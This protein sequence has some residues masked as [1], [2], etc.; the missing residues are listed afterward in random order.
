M[1]SN[2]PSLCVLLALTACQVPATLPKEM[3][4]VATDA[5]A[6]RSATVATSPTSEDPQVIAADSTELVLVQ[7]ALS[8]LAVLR[9]TALRNI[10]NANTPGY[11]RRVIATPTTGLRGAGDSPL[12]VAAHEESFAVFTNGPLQV[13]GRSLDVAIEGDGFF[14]VTLPSGETAFT[15]NSVWHVNADGKLVT[16]QGHVL[17]PEITV[18]SDLL[19]LSVDPCGGVGG[20]TAGSPATTTMFGDLT[21]HRFVNPEGLRADGT[22]WMPTDASGSPITGAPGQAGLGVLQQ[23]CIERSNVELASELLTLQSIDQQHRSIVQ[24]LR[25]LGMLAH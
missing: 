25:E 18:P 5:T 10:A 20:R 24:V 6:H 16:G 21:L 2:H 14:A 9:R 3:P 4:A 15:R 23:G 11:K 7:A 8:N 22:V 1:R 13:T 17:L 19:E 12:P